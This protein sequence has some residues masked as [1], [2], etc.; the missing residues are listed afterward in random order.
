LEGGDGCKCV[1]KESCS[2]GSGFLFWLVNQLAVLTMERW[3]GAD[4]VALSDFGYHSDVV[5]V[6]SLMQEVVGLLLFSVGDGTS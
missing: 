5:S 3:E 6:F 1:G 4:S 2:K